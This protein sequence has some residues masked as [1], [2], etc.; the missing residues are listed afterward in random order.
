MSTNG[1]LTGLSKESEAAAWCRA[2]KHL[3]VDHLRVDRFCT[4]KR[5]PGAP[6]RR[7]KT[8]PVLIC[9]RAPRAHMHA[10]TRLLLSRWGR[11]RSSFAGGQ[12]AAAGTA[13]TRARTDTRPARLGAG[14]GCTKPQREGSQ[15]LRGGQHPPKGQLRCAPGPRPVLI[16]IPQRA[17]GV[18]QAAEPLR[19]GRPLV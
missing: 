13:G 14:G 5:A 10:Q 8:R 15:K 16:P 9:R 1:D 6:R 17:R 4:Q 11:V 7:A 3:R 2:A 19:A 18:R 12:P